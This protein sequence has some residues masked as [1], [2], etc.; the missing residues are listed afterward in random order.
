MTDDLERL[1]GAEWSIYVSLC[2]DSFAFF[3]TEAWPYIEQTR[4]LLPSV[5]FDALTAALQA[6][7]ERRLRRIAIACPPGVSKSLVGAV[8]W[9][10]W[11]LLRSG[12]A[13]RIMAGSYSW[14]FASRDARRCRDLMQTPWYRSLV[15]NRWKLTVD[16]ETDVWT[17]SG[18]R[19]LIVSV[20]GKALGERCTYQVVDDAL[21]G[22][23]VHSAAAKK[24]AAR[25]IAEVL[26]SR[27]EDPEGDPRVVI[28]QRLCI[29][30][31]IA[32]CLERGWSLLCLPAVLSETDQPCELRDDRGEL[33]WRDPR[34]PGEPLLSLLSP[35]ALDQ[36]KSELGSSAFAA[37]YGQRP[38]D[39]GSAILKRSWWRFHHGEHVPPNAPRPAGCDTEQPAIPTPDTFDAKVIG[40]D[41]TFGSAK[42]DFAVA[43]CWGRKGGARFLLEQWRAR[44]GFE[45]QVDAIKAMAARHPTAKIIIEKAANGAAV[46]ET[47]QRELS[48]VVPVAALGSKAAR[49]SA[50]A[51]AAESG[52]LHLPLG[53]PYLEE[54][55]EELAGA[56]KFDDSQDSAAYSVHA[57]ASPI[58]RE[59]AGA[60]PGA[61]ITSTGI[62]WGGEGYGHRSTIRTYD[63]THCNYGGGARVALDDD[64]RWD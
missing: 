54:L 59:S 39:D 17:S 62:H 46:I 42:G 31:P 34:K 14:E 26:P 22:A 61:L 43:Q 15:A 2:V 53:V 6:V 40:C 37:Q 9:P 63:E 60:A 27:L 5:A 49:L 25:W 64:D 29:D 30:D 32:S 33:V 4:A 11:L 44:A 21:S 48:G 36:L 38:A 18:G 55:V 41:L 58:V 51:P 19:R 57:L 56:T 52:S 35:E 12:G 20:G 24:E 13:A 7:A 16:R 23:D 3:A 45:A 1:A 47:L 28:G 8:A 50:I 10:A